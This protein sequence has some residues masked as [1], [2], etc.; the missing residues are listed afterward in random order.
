MRAF[1][2][3]WFR[4]CALLFVVSSVLVDGVVVNISTGSLSGYQARSSSGKL[5]NIFKVSLSS[6]HASV[7]HFYLPVSQPNL[8]VRA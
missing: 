4:P 1:Q 3:Q 5:V 2:M 6:S 8:V 7:R